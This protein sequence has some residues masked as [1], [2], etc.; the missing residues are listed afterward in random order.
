MA[1]D[2][3]SDAEL[4]QQ[5]ISVADRR[6]RE[7]QALEEAK[8]AAATTTAV[9]VRVEGCFAVRCCGPRRLN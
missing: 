6:I 3:A 2:Q 1:T 9:E 5:S 8:R 4:M 7:L